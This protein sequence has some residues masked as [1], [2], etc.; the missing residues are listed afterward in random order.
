MRLFRLSQDDIVRAVPQLEGATLKCG[1]CNWEASAYFWLADNRNSALEEIQRTIKQ[2][3]FPLCAGC[4]A[5]M[6]SECTYEIKG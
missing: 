3:G 5:E 1:C 2:G 4:M 6:L